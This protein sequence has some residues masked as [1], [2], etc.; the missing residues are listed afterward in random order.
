MAVEKEFAGGWEDGD[1]Q[2][3]G[4]IPEGTYPAIIRAG[5]YFP[6]NGDR[7]AAISIPVYFPKFGRREW[8]KFSEKAPRWM[9]KKTMDSL[10]G[11]GNTNQKNLAEMLEKIPVTEAMVQVVHSKD[12]KYANYRLVSITNQEARSNANGREE[13][14]F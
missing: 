2:D 3:Q 14:P 8:M 10:V 1:Q 12:G 13:L 9:V 11:E 6:R 4:L 5:N 7:A